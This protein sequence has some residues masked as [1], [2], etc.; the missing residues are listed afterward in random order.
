MHDNK[1]ETKKSTQHRQLGSLL[2]E[3][4]SKDLTIMTATA[5]R[6]QEAKSACWG[7]STRSI[8]AFAVSIFFILFFVEWYFAALCKKY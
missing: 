1:K 6:I 8:F 5:K 3:I 7:V 2:D 4:D